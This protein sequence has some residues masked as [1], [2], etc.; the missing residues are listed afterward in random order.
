MTGKRPDPV[1]R[2]LP[3]M[4]AP[5]PGLHIVATPIGNAG[6]I[7][8]RALTIL[9]EADAV[10]CED[11]REASKLLGL[12]GISATLVP[13]H[14]HNAER[15]RPQLLDRLGAG[16]VVALISDAGMPLI[17]DPG[18]KLVREV[19]AAGHPV[20]CAPGASAV[21][22]A[23]ALSG[24]PTDRFLFA[25]FPPPR[26][27]ARQTFLRDLADV[28]AT[29]ILYES[30]RRLPAALADMAAV[31]G[32][33]REAAVARELT[34]LYEEVRRGPLADLAAHYDGAGPPKGEVVVVIGPPA[35][36]AET[37]AVDLDDHLR[38]AL[39]QGSL[40][41]AVEVVST[42]TGRPRKEVYRRALALSAGS[43]EDAGG[44]RTDMPGEGED[45]GAGEGPP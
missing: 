35:P 16:Q 15:M 13:Y 2:L 7:T 28:P 5:T 41:D 1:D 11:T 40:R 30:A 26:S 4:K 39:G 21:P 38:T 23:L 25:G 3:R 22:T 43:A 6:D 36:T 29:L 18:Y 45:E 17:S 19:V 8:L 37:G 32:G 44:A 14:E 42:A 34:K 31:L 20:T 24:L 27:G 10:A 9:A 12:Y 33:A